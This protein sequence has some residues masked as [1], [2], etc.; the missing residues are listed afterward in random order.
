MAKTTKA[1]PKK[2]VVKKSTPKTTKATPKKKTKKLTKK[3]PKKLKKYLGLKYKIK[4]DQLNKIIKD[5]I[6]KGENKRFVTYEEL[7][8]YI[9]YPEHNLKAIEEIYETLN[10]SQIDVVNNISLLENSEELSREEIL[11]DSSL[12]S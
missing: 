10:R 3:A 7:L 8:L 9:P 11:K 1:T 12:E 2:K 5:L 6:K 4:K